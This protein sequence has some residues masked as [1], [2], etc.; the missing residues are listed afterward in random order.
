MTPGLLGDARFQS[1]FDGKAREI[2]RPLWIT[3]LCKGN[4][5]LDPQFSQTL[6]ISSGFRCWALSH[7]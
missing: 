3:A 6:K 4:R 2:I 1:A 5:F 7:G